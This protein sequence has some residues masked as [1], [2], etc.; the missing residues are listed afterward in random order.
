MSLHFSCKVL[1]AELC[2]YRNYIVVTI[3]Y[4]L[5]HFLTALSLLRHSTYIRCFAGDTSISVLIYIIQIYRS[6]RC[7]ELVMNFQLCFTSLRTVQRLCCR[8]L[9][10]DWLYRGQPDTLLQL[11]PLAF[12]TAFIYSQVKNIYCGAYCEVSN[13]SQLCSV[14][15]LQ[16]LQ[17]CHSET[18]LFLDL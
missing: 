9:L 14:L 3:P 1:S 7:R 18:S 4:P 15:Q 17:L 8:V 16:S 12:E 2:R 10:P 13:A 11:L 5:L 6:Y